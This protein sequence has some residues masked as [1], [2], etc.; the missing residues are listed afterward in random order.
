MKD[1][2]IF[3]K[4]NIIDLLIVVVLIAAV[5][6]IISRLSVSSSNSIS[7]SD[8]FQFVVSVDSVREYTV[9]GLQKKGDV[10]SEETDVRVGEIIDVVVEPMKADVVTFDGQRKFIERPGR[11]TAYVTIK[12]DGN[13]VNDC[14][15]TA[16]KEEIG[17]GREYRVI[18]KY[19]STNGK[20]ISVGSIE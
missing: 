13:F 9:N 3:G 20:T 15:Y 8:Q 5:V 6:G 1:G 10:F 14:Y 19:V 11:Y 18:S 17:A 12:A 16:D 4:I 7:G 2:K